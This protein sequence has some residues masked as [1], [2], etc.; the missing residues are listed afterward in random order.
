VQTGAPT[1]TELL[2]KLIFSR[3]RGEPH[4]DEDV[5]DITRQQLER[6]FQTNIFGMFYM[7][8]KPQA[9]ICRRGQA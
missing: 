7:V 8:P 1:H 4:K 2:A 5:I 3:T 9:P 6:T